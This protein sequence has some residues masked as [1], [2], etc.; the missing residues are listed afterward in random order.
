MNSRY[1][2]TGDTLISYLPSTFSHEQKLSSIKLV[3]DIRWAIMRK[4]PIGFSYNGDSRIVIP[5]SL[6]LQDKTW[7]RVTNITHPV[8]WYPNKMTVE[9]RWARKAVWFDALQVLDKSGAEDQW[10]SF[11]IDK[12]DNL[13]ALSIREIEKIFPY[14]N[15]D[16]YMTT[17]T[18]SPE[19]FVKNWNY[20]FR[21]IMTERE[22]RYDL[23][24]PETFYRENL[25]S[26]EK[27]I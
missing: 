3:E 6:Y 27:S 5:A 7:T 16:D 18:E 22:G 17:P 21:R 23:R 24:V 15:D 25:Q 4:L 11:H 26:E 8:N 9:T 14:L 10:K 20:W 13:R 12:V 1:I 2:I 19:W